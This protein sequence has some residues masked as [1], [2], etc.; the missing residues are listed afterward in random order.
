V[1]IQG[2][3]NLA[4]GASVANVLTGSVFEFVRRPSLVRVWLAGDAAGLMRATVQS[5]TDVLLEESPISRVN[6]FPDVNDLPVQDAADPGDRLKVGARN[7]AGVAAD[8]FWVVEV[9]EVA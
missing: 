4:A 7:T 8:L 3:T 1:R 5:G 9:I 2:V 6:R